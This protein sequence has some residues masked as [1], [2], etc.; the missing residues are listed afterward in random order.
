MF[1]MAQS[2]STNSAPSGNAPA[3]PR[4]PYGKTGIQ[5]SII[6]FGG[7]AVDSVPQDQAD[8]LVAEVIER[9]VNYFDVAP[10][11]AQEHLGP[12]LRP[13][14]KNVFL[15]CKTTER[16][17]DRAAAE[18]ARSLQLLQTDYLDLYQLHGLND[19]AKDV[20]TAFAKG[21]VMELI[22]QAKKSGQVRHVG[23]SAHTT[24]AAIAALDR[25]PFDS[26]MFP[27]NFASWLSGGFGPEISAAAI[28]RGAARIALKAMA[29]QR[30]ASDDR[31]KRDH[32][33]CWYQPL[34][35]PDEAALCLRWTLDQDVTAAIT[36]GEEPLIRLAIEVAQNYQPLSPHE[37]QCVRQLSETVKPIFS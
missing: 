25:Y 6:G 15:A 23:V 22:A 37:Q 3:L 2:N 34:T 24:A 19:M 26:V 9:G 35:D 21:G 10:T 30:W 13:Y 32:P 33:K 5:L 18:L 7:L 4:R 17:A 36:P 31:A 16:M 11:D 20:D 1:V 29:R 8:R 12:A 14:R 28:A 27:V